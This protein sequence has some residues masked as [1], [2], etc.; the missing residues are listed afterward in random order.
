MSFFVKNITYSSTARCFMKNGFC[1]G[2]FL[3]AAEF[4]FLFKLLVSLDD[5]SC[6]SFRSEQLQ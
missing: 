1:T 4:I 3:G 6:F 5:L 2:H